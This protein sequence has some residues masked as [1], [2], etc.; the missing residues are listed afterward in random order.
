MIIDGCFYSACSDNACVDLPVLL[1]LS[2][3]TNLSWN[4]IDRQIFD[5]GI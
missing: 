4:C 1:G 3:E 5:E 2:G